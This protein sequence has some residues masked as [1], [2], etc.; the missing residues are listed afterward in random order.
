M[1][2]SRK[3]LEHELN[4]AE[5]RAGRNFEKLMEIDKII[6]KAD[7]KHELAILTLKDIKRVLEFG[8]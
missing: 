6:K 2:M 1:R 8:I 7:E 5:F 4:K 3:E